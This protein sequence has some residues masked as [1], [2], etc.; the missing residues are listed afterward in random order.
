MREWPIG[1]SRRV[2]NVV[3]QLFQEKRMFTKLL[4]PVRASIL[5]F[6]VAAALAGVSCTTDSTPNGPTQ[7]QPPAQ[8]PAAARSSSAAGNDVMGHGMHGLLATFAAVALGLTAF[9]GR[10][11]LPRT[12]RGPSAD[13][14]APAERGIPELPRQRV[15]TAPVTPSGRTIQVAAGGD[16][17]AAIDAARPGDAIALDPG[18]TYRGPFRLPKKNGD[19]WIVIAPR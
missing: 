10:F 17:Q 3:F 18:A 14:R 7:P 1:C 5:V 13:S 16:L 15:A 4:T 12:D 19:A 9:A 6:A 8:T 11:E 2:P